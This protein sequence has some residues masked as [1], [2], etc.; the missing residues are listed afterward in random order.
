ML[1]NN[2]VTVLDYVYV[3]VFFFFSVL[4]LCL[5]YF[6]TV[7]GELKIIFKYINKVICLAVPP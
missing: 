5:L 7:V 2:I 3:S 6:I 4:L 1:F